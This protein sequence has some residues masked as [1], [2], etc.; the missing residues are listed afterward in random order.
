MK[1]VAGEPRRRL[2][3]QWIPEI[4]IHSVADLQ[5]ACGDHSIGFRSRAIYG[6]AP[7]NGYNCNIACSA[8]FDRK[9]DS[10]PVITMAAKPPTTPKMHHSATDLLLLFRP[11]SALI[12]NWN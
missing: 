2:R 5:S 11:E 12:L 6:I 4:D 10:T 7:Q 9:P 1:N 8:Q 3:Y